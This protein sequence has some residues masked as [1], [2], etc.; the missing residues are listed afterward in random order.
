MPGSFDPRGC[1]L[2]GIVLVLTAWRLPPPG[3][4]VV[5]GP[6]SGAPP[7]HCWPPLA[8]PEHVRGHPDEVPSSPSAF[9]I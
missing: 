8:E 5:L 4:T 1:W 2:S 7:G 6:H 3:P 9:W